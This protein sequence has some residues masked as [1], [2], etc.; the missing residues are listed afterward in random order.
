MDKNKNSCP[1]DWNKYIE[2][3]EATHFLKREVKR[4]MRINDAFE[5]RAQLAYAFGYGDATAG[6]DFDGEFCVDD[7][8]ME[9]DDDE[10]WTAQ[11][12]DKP[13]GDHEHD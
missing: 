11:E 13:K 1:I 7:I 5:F 3:C 6:L 2:Q 10:V 8:Y 12:N 9:Q 4:L